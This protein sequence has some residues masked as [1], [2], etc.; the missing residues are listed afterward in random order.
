MSQLSSPSIII[1]GIGAYV[2]EKRLTNEELSK[3]VETN[4]EWIRTRSGIS[5]RRI[6]EPQQ[7]TS[8]MSTEAAKRALERA[9]LKPEDID[10][11]VVATI[12]PDM[13]FPST[14]CMIQH[15][16]GMRNVACFD[17]QA[18]CSG[19]VY[20]LEVASQMM[21]SGAYRNALVIGAEKLSSIV[22]WQD[23]TTCVLFGDGAGAAVLSRVD[24]PGVGILGCMLGADGENPNLLYMPGGGCAQ[25]A[26]EESVR[27]R[28]H[29]IKMNGKEIFKLAVRV[30]EQAA[31]EILARN[32]VS[33]EQLSLLI[34]HQANIRIIQ[35]IAERLAL[36]PEKCYV[37]IDRMGNTSAASIPLALEEAVSTGRIKS[38]DYVLFV[39][40]GAGLTWGA[41]LLKWA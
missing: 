20:G 18:A 3:T 14:A 11:L 12:T 24:T 8:D 26:T 32:G 31:N 29:F 37:N 27:N 28:Q 22:D 1:K 21:R 17:I 15:K 33:S 10:L 13:P 16:L 19:F 25:P 7:T 9:G 38:G 39:A 34:P 6:A 23:R 4:D 41:V 30:M 40:F 36:P 5:E 35:A 2:P